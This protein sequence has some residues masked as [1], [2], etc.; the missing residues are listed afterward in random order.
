MA[1]HP[2]GAFNMKRFSK[3]REYVADAKRAIEEA[4]TDF[5]RLAGRGLWFCVD[6]VR[7]V[8]QPLGR[9]EVWAT[10]H[11]LASGSPFCYGEPGC[12]L[13]LFDEARLIQVADRVQKA[14]HLP[15]PVSLDFADRIATKYHDGVTFKN[16]P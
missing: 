6:E 13:C 8:G 14:L 10:L 1:A 9:I 5:C 7:L 15:R 16:M 3:H 12:H 11:F 4:V 2:W